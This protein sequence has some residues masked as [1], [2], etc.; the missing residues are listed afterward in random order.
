MKAMRLL[1]LALSIVTLSAL[2]QAARATDYLFVGDYNGEEVLRF[3]MTPAINPPRR[4]FHRD[5]PAQ[6]AGDHQHRQHSHCL[7]AEQRAC[8]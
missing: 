5:R 7:T 6:N 1:P 8:R 4:R 3:T 2:S